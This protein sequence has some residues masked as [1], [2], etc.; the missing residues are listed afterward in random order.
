MV[1]TGVQESFSKKSDWIPAKI[2]AGMTTKLDFSLNL[3]VMPLPALLQRGG[4]PPFERFYKKRSSSL[5]KG[6]TGW[7]CSN[8]CQFF[9]HIMAQDRRL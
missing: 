6:R 5:G 4:I 1:L 3:T 2:I 8:H 7:I 9:H